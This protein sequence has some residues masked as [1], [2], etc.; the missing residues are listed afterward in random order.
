MPNLDATVRS[1][2]RLVALLA[3]LLIALAIA[4][5]FAGYVAPMFDSLAHFRLHLG[6]AALLVAAVLAGTRW[7]L[8]A[9]VPATACVAALATTLPFVL[10]AASDAGTE[11]QARYTLLQMNVL[12]KTENYVPALQRIAD[13][14]P[15]IVTLQEMTSGWRDALAPL[16][17][18]YP[19]QLHCAGADGRWGDSAILSRRPFVATEP[20]V[21]DERNSLAIATVDLNGVPVTIVS[22]HQLWPWP[23]RQWQRLERIRPTLAELPGPVLLAGDFNAVPWSALIDAYEETLGARAVHGIGS[24]W[25]VDVLPIGWARVIGLPIDNILATPEIGIVSAG[26]L[27][28]TSSD[29]LPVLVRFTVLPPQTAPVDATSVAAAGAYPAKTRLNAGRSEMRAR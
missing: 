17:A 15:D 4:A 21:C 22:H 5:G 23:F 8:A 10:P 14:A 13:E 26:T 3:G 29:H 25:L 24:T 19:Y 2:F 7:K 18:A 27:N 16:Q 6:V 20:T 1:A 28:A 11:G 12:Y 9:L